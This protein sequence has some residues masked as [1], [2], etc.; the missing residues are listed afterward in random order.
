MHTPAGFE[1]RDGVAHATDWW[2]I[3]FNPSMPYRLSHM[4]ERSVSNEVVMSKIHQPK[5]SMHRPG[6][7]V[8][9]WRLRQ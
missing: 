2:A 9:R 4:V 5:V 7:P 8:R 3:V 1:L 6:N